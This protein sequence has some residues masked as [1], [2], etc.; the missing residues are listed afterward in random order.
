MYDIWWYRY[1]H[2]QIGVCV[3][4]CVCVYR[5]YI[6][7]YTPCILSPI[8][9]GSFK[10]FKAV[11]RRHSSTPCGKLFLYKFLV[12]PNVI[13]FRYEERVSESEHSSFRALGCLFLFPNKTC[14]VLVLCNFIIQTLSRDNGLL[15]STI[16]PFMHHQI[17]SSQKTHCCSSKGM[18]IG[19]LDDQGNPWKVS[20]ESCVSRGRK[21]GGTEPNLKCLWRCYPPWNM[22]E[23]NSEFTPENQWLED[24]ISFWDSLFSRVMLLSGRV[25]CP[26]SEKRY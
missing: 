11:K 20:P 21:N 23:T 26:P 12:P 14:C 16:S 15:R 18:Y 17:I 10:E 6:Y 2:L 4:V 8:S 9:L 25:N 13:G 1:M 22:P 7:I 24:E 5:R 19:L 3:C